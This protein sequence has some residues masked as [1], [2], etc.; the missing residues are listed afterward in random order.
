MTFLIHTTTNK[1]D[2]PLARININLRV[3]LAT[4]LG[5]LG[6]ALFCNQSSALA[7]MGWIGS[8][9]ANGATFTG[10][11]IVQKSDGSLG[12]EGLYTTFHPL[13]FTTASTEIWGVCFPCD[14]FSSYPRRLDLLR[15][16][17]TA[18]P[19]S[20]DFLKFFSCFFFS[21]LSCLA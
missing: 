14:Y 3:P 5:V 18:L 6:G 10:A 7:N 8:R 1:H 21:S 20:S 19:G 9:G 15:T 11:I 13:Y 12:E 16:N 17:H 2:Y 4:C